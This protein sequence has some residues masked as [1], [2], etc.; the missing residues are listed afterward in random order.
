MGKEMGGVE[1]AKYGDVLPRGG[2]C[3]WWEKFNASA[4]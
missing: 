4:K 1:M 2:G 3:W